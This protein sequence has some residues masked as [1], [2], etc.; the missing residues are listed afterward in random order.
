MKHA[1]FSLIELMIVVTII[2][3]LVVI[4]YPS[5]TAHMER[6][7]RSDGQSALLDLANRMDQYFN[8]NHHYTGAT[9]TQLG[10]NGNSPEG[11]YSLAIENLSDN[12]FNLKAFPV[13][14][15][16]GDLCG[17]LSLNQ[18]GQRNFSGTTV[19]LSDCW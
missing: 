2:G 9:L 18:L 14:A 6:A 17:T 12:A 1:G 4:A 7:R 16:S 11:Y 3:I 19:T 5:Y 8:E 13:G 15:Q 10:V